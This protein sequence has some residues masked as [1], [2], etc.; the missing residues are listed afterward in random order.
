MRREGESSGSFF[1]AAGRLSQFN[2]HHIH[3]IP[4]NADGLSLATIQHFG[5]TGVAACFVI[6]KYHR[7]NVLAA[8][9]PSFCGSMA[10]IS[11]TRWSLAPTL[12]SADGSALA[13]CAKQLRPIIATSTRDRMLVLSAAGQGHLHTIHPRSLDQKPRSCRLSGRNRGRQKRK[14][15]HDGR[16]LP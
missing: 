3:G 9:A 12:A 8:K 15:R 7:P 13:F 1:R 14:H 4:S 5:L 11:T 2:C 10:R 6:R 16:G